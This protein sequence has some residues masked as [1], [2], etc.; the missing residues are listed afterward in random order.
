MPIIV[1]YKCPRTKKIFEDRNK[2]VAHLKRT[3][4]ESLKTP[5]NSEEHFR[6]KNLRLKC[7]AV[8]KHARSFDDVTQWLSSHLRVLTQFSYANGNIAKKLALETGRVEKLEFV[9]TKLDPSIS[10][11]DALYIKSP[12][13]RNNKEAKPLY[14]L[15]A[16]GQIRY[17]ATS[18]IKLDDFLEKFFCMDVGSGWSTE[19]TTDDPVL[20]PHQSSFV[21]LAEDWP[22]IAARILHENKDSDFYD[23]SQRL[24]RIAFP[25]ITE[26]KYLQFRDSGLL[27]DDVR[28]FSNF[29]FQFVEMATSPLTRQLDVL[30]T[31][32]LSDLTL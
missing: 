22:F 28:D 6:I 16:R 1:A 27:P 8:R 20:T 11:R 12:N 15:G 25:G 2:Y 26:E 7:D 4:I 3:A 13:R 29:M 31:D 21:A 24:L 10:E 14:Y 32:L 9:H 5:Y 17:L 30:P 23:S 18:G 19:L